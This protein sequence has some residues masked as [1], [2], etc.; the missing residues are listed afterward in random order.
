MDSECSFRRTRNLAFFALNGRM[1]LTKHPNWTE[2]PNEAHGNNSCCVIKL[3]KVV[4]HCAKTP[5][6][7]RLPCRTCPS[8]STSKWALKPNPD[9]KDAPNT[10]LHRE[11]HESGDQVDDILIWRY[12]PRPRAVH[13]PPQH[14]RHLFQIPNHM[15]S[16]ALTLGNFSIKTMGISPI[17]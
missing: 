8:D 2:C 5:G 1:I 15:P 13:P 3:E 7:R 17:N 11:I 12:H 6:V 16:Y 4:N 9:F 10:R 14:I